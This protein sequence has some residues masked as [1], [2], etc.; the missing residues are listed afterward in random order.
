MLLEGF[1]FSNQPAA[2][3]DAPTNIGTT[4]STNVYDLGIARDIGS[5]VTEDLNLLI[6]VIT[7][8]T[9]GGSATLQVALKGA[10]DNGS[11]S[12]GSYSILYQSDAIAVASLV[13]GYRF[14]MGGLLSQNT[15]ALVRFLKVSYI[16]GTAAMTAG[17]IVAGFTPALQHNPTY[18]RG[19]VA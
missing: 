2:G 11:G 8:F 17:A 4:D 18:A 1:M 13:Q 5:A 16:I 12:P 19:Y 15:T 3:G 14:L 9:S 6:Q 10:P 7:A